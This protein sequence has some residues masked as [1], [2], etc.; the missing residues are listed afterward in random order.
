MKKLILGTLLI[1][2]SILA[3][4]N[5]Q[6]NNPFKMVEKISIGIEHDGNAI[7]GGFNLKNK[8]IKLEFSTSQY[9]RGT[10]KDE[11]TAYY[12][13]AFLT[14]YTSNTTSIYYGARIGIQK[15]ENDHG[16]IIAPTFGFEYFLNNKISFG[17]DIMYYDRELNNKKGI[18][19]MI[20]LRYYFNSI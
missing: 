15:T 19:S 13:G 14:E 6:I 4:D 7:Y 16:N 8:N 10:P 17:G 11:F 20:M 18:D 12:F 1:S 2:S 9:K 5:T 3:A